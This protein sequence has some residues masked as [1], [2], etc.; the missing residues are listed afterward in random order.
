MS[1]HT[2]SPSGYLPRLVGFGLV[3]FGML[4]VVASDRTSLT[5]GSQEFGVIFFMVGWG[6]AVLGISPTRRGEE[7]ERTIHTPLVRFPWAGLAIVGIASAIPIAWSVYGYGWTSRA[8]NGV[9]LVAFGLV[10]AFA[11]WVWDQIQ[12]RRREKP[13][14]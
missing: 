12:R 11:K 6:V 5:L 3:A 14:V 4:T 10:V 13:P 7:G 2:Y 8:M 9:G 1:N